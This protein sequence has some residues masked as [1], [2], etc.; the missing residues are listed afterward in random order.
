MTIAVGS[1]LVFSCDY[2]DNEWDK[3]HN[4]APDPSAD[5][6]VQFKN[7]SQSFETKV[8]ATTNQQIE[9]STKVVV[10]IMGLPLDQ[11]LTVN[12]SVDPSSTLEPDMYVLGSTSLTIPAGSVSASTTVT[13]V[14]ENMPIDVFLDLVL[15]MD[16]G[17]NNS[18]SGTK[19]VYSFKK[20]PFCPLTNG[21][22][23][24]EG[25]WSVTSQYNDYEDPFTAA[26][27]S[28]T[29]LAV[30]G[31]GETFIGTSGFWFEDVVSGGT[32][33]MTI[34]GN[35]TVNI[36]RQYIYTTI[37][38]GANYDY[39]IAGSGTWNNCGDKL[40]LDFKYDIYYPGDSSGLA[41]T[42]G[43]TY[44]SGPDLGGVFTLD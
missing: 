9:I 2:D 41:A 1:L 13:S 11:D 3:L 35:G 36:P 17:G 28:T 21:A 29:T 33:N 16:S 39:E 23:D 19:L 44:L 30:S 37:Y 20:F 4:H 22:Y 27:V 12:L 6:F 14:S 7:A 42:Y 40:V 15:T 24:F 38:S 8:D 10:A 26:A 34:N 25:S 31:V 18:D 43:P 5:F 32:F